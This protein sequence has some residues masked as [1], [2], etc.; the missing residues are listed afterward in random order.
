MKFLKGAMLLILFGVFWLTSSLIKSHQL[1]Q[2]TSNGKIPYGPIPNVEENYY[3]YDGPKLA[4][5]SHL[6]LKRSDEFT[7]I[8]FEKLILSSLDTVAKKNVQKYLSLTLD[9]SVDYQVDP[10]WVISIMM[11]ESRFD[12]KA[13]SHKNARGLMQIKPETA[14]HLYQLMRKKVSEERL[15]ANLH[16]PSEN[17][18]V[19]IFYLKKLLHNFGMN[20]RLATI[21]YNI[22]PN[23]LKKLL[24]TH[25]VDTDSFSYLTKVEVGYQEFSKSFAQEL[26]KRPRPFEKTYVVRGQGRLLDEQFIKLY[27]MIIPTLKPNILLS[28]ENLVHLSSHSLPF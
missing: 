23:K 6:Q 20:Y 22:G 27:A 8:E 10:F 17:I 19:G 16:R 25:K 18:E 24:R 12:L 11:V 26:K 13:L 9:L 7:K 1:N 15:Y 2:L 5:N 3:S 28:S 21:A 14:G 4:F